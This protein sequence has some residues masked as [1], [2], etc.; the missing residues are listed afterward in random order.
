M[1]Q[2]VYQILYANGRRVSFLNPF[3]VVRYCDVIG[4]MRCM[5][6]YRF[7]CLLLAICF[8][9]MINRALL[10]VAGSRNYCFCCGIRSVEDI[11]YICIDVGSLLGS[12]KY[13][14]S[15]ED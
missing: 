14:L 3:M 12:S 4:R 10:F 2:T 13:I 8:L 5:S 9:I 6:C 15:L 11:G 7:L 1:E